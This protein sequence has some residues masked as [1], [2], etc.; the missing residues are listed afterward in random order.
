MVISFLSFSS[1]YF[2]QLYSACRKP[3]TNKLAPVSVQVCTK[4]PVKTNTLHLPT[5]TLSST[6]I[7][8]LTS[9]VPD[10]LSLRL[11]SRAFCSSESSP[12]RQ[13]C[14]CGGGAVTS[15]M[16][17]VPVLNH[18]HMPQWA[19]E[20]RDSVH[21]ISLFYSPIFSEKWEVFKA[22]VRKNPL[23]FYRNIWCWLH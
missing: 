11:S 4:V 9:C 15:S 6:L 21:Q 7:L 12:W 1:Q 2:T 10:W 23:K 20:L 22:K 8:K 5:H 14:S 3:P 16:Q 17:Q 19:K 13:R 18:M